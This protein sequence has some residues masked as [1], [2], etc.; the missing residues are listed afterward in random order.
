[1]NNAIKHGSAKNIVI[2]LGKRNNRG[3]LIVE[4]DGAGFHVASVSEFGLGLCIMNYRAKMAGGSVDLQSSPGTGN[5]VTCRFP[6]RD[7]NE[8]V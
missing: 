3:I 4:A 2:R 5:V 1:V 8:N 6:V 7:Q